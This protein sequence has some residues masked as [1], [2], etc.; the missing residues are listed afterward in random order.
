MQKPWSAEFEQLLLDELA[1]CDPTSSLEPDTPL[2]HYGLTSLSTL[3]LSSKLVSRYGIEL[4]AFDE[5]AFRTPRSL[6]KLVVGTSGPSANGVTMSGNR[7]G[8]TDGLAGRFAAVASRHPDEPCLVDNAGALTYAETAARA[9]A[10]AAAIGAGGVVAVLG[11][12]EITT[13]CAY[14]G[15][16]CAGATIVPLSMDFPPDRNADI[17]R[18]AGARCVVHTEPRGEKP[19]EAQLAA[20]SGVPVVDAHNAPLTSWDPGVGPVTA[21]T[22]AYLLFTS[23]STGRPKGVRITHGN[24]AAFLAAALPTYRTGPGE[25]FSQCHGLTFDFSVF[26]MWGAWSTGS[27][28]A[29]VPRVHALNPASTIAQHGVTV[30]ACTPSLIEAAAAAGNLAP[31][32]L[33][34]LRHVVIGGEPLRGKTVALAR[35]AAPNAII[36]NVYGPTETTVWVSTYRLTPADPIPAHPIMPIGSPTAG[37]DIEISEEGELLVAGPQVFDGYADPALDKDKLIHQGDR[38]WYRTGDLGERDAGVLHHRGRLDGQVKIRGYRIELG[39]IEHAATRLL[40]V[41]TAAARIPGDHGDAG[42]ALFVEGTA[43]DEPWLRLELGRSLPAYMVPDRV[44]ATEAFPLNPHG[45]LDRTR[46]AQQMTSS[47]T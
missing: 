36:D 12:R 2:A 18:Q 33:S 35:A 3:A 11:E 7:I 17:V 30:W 41:R 46:L 22:P 28:L 16:L 6:W 13:Y 8:L 23:G 40:G 43:V 9:A 45:K 19:L 24:V 39:E 47:P 15:V 42:L 21:D 5:R 1:L 38:T 32:S 29:V 26:E 44:I 27:A 14:L 20:M 25:V 31:G 34:G 4:P 37:A 10:L